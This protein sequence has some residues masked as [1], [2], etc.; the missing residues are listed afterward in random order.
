MLFWFYFHQ[1]FTIDSWFHLTSNNQSLIKCQSV[2][3]VNERK[4]EKVRFENHHQ[5]N[6]SQIQS[7]HKSTNQPNQ[8]KQVKSEMKSISF[9]CL[10]FFQ[11]PINQSTN[12]WEWVVCLFVVSIV[13]HLNWCLICFA[14]WN[15]FNFPFIHSFNQSSLMMMMNFNWLWQQTNQP[16]I[17]LIV[18]RLL[19]S[20]SIC[21]LSFLFSINQ[22]N[23]FSRTNESI[24][25]W[26]M[27]R[28]NES[29][30]KIEIKSN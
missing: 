8:R 3:W 12:H 20:I 19:V 11:F 13:S 30:N 15:Q 21:Q 29:V 5:I 26:Q 4:K 24:D 7:T 6:Q 2:K 1:S 28:I 22:F 10:T 25:Q 17:L 27:K 14:C 9:L 16:T 18:I 23:S